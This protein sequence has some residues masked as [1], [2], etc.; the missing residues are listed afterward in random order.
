MARTS[1][2]D[3]PSNF[4]Y[5]YSAM[6]SF[7]DPVTDPY[8]F[9]DSPPEPAFHPDSVPIYAILLLFFPFDCKRHRMTWP[10]NKPRGP[11]GR[12]VHFPRYSTSQRL[13]VSSRSHWWQAHPPVTQ[14]ITLG[15]SPK[16]SESGT[17]G[18]VS[19]MFDPRDPTNH[20]LSG[21]CTASHNRTTWSEW[22]FC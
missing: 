21:F 12:A 19:R 18:A 15:G 11:M 20:L 13:V 3:L 1:T 7:P 4:T 2:L 10:I 22:H 14:N 17:A 8:D 9:H 6:Q 5:V 16:S